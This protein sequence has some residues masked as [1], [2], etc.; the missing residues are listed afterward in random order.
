MITD[1]FGNGDDLLGALDALGDLQQNTDQAIL[2]QRS[3]ERVNLRTRVRVRPGNASQRFDV[4]LTGVTADVSGGGSQVL[5]KR[6]VLAGDYFFLSFLD[7]ADTIGEIL[8]RCIRCRMV[9][10]EVFEVGLQ[11]EHNIDPSQLLSRRDEPG[12]AR[13]AA[14]ADDLSSL[15]SC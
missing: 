7:H 14:E 2:A 8:C 15:A 11:F 3:S 4:E 9:Q 13:H 6:P 5:L 1:P 10:E 12:I